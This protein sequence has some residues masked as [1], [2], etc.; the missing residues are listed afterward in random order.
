MTHYN[1]AA[2]ACAFY[3]AAIIFFVT[4]SY[5]I[6]TGPD[7]ALYFSAAYH[8][9]EGLGVLDYRYL[10]VTRYPP[11]YSLMLALFS[12]L[13]GIDIPSAARWCAVL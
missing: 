1:A 12:R 9:K 8:I 4:S 6:H 11:L 13:A 5:G 3:A 10:P 7:S 2:F